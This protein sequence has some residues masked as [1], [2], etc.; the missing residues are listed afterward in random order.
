MNSTC[1]KTLPFCALIRNYTFMNEGNSALMAQ[2]PLHDENVD[3]GCNE[4]LRHLQGE[5]NVASYRVQ[6]CGREQAQALVLDHPTFLPLTSIPTHSQIHGPQRVSHCI[7]A[8]QFVPGPFL[9][10]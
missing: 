6:L 3:Y 4:S 5:I 1:S 7:D 10:S 2:S 9:F 8:T